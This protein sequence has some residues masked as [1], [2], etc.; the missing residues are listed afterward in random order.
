MTRIVQTMLKKLHFAVA[1][2]IAIVL[3]SIPAEAASRLKDI[4]QVEGVREN[5]LIGYG[6]VAGLN[7]SGDTLQN[8]PFTRQSIEAMLER[9][10]VN[11]RG[12]QMRGDNIAAVMV[13]ASLP[14]FARPGT[15]IDVTISAMGDAEDLRGGALLATPLYGMDGEIYAVAQGN[16]AVAGFSAEGAA[17]SVVQGV[18]TSGRVANGAIIER[19]T[20]FELAQL[21]NVR[22]SLTN[23]DFTTARR[24]ADVINAHF[25]N[26]IARSLDPSTVLLNRSMQPQLALV[27]LITEIETLTVTTDQRAR[28]LIDDKSGIIVMGSNVRIDEVAVAQGNLT[29]RITETPLVSQPAPFSDTGQTAIVPRT[30]VE[31]DDTDQTRLTVLS[32]GITLQDLVDGLN[33]LGI[34]PRDMIAILQAIKAAGAMQA[35]IEVM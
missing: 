17:G 34:G 26:S 31:V 13:T 2:G 30:D 5:H 8:I 33:A 25:G 12:Q 4:V 24:I 35:D 29:I 22:L 20:P 15:R 14:P 11:V 32:P 3:L 19:Q 7:G 27:D 1:L 6:L 16:V 23:P 18:P 10:G 28:V 9:L 21:Q